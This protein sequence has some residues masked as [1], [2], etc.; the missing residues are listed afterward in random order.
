MTLQIRTCW[1][2]TANWTANGLCYSLSSLR[3]CEP[4]TTDSLLFFFPLLPRRRRHRCR[5]WLS[6]SCS[7]FPRRWRCCHCRRFRSTTNS[8]RW[9]DRQVMWLLVGK[10]TWFLWYRWSW[11]CTVHVAVLWIK[12]D[13]YRIGEFRVY[14]PLCPHPPRERGHN[15]RS[16]CPLTFD[17]RLTNK[18][19]PTIHFVFLSAS[20]LSELAFFYSPSLFETFWLRGSAAT[21]DKLLFQTLPLVPPFPRSYPLLASSISRN[22]NV[23]LQCALPL[24]NLS[25]SLSLFYSNSMMDEWNTK[26]LRRE[27]ETISAVNEQHLGMRRWKWNI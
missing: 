25:F 12:G 13:V 24:S 5:R 21:F 17:V 27:D 26:K 15:L 22:S 14:R 6:S 8:G 1:P 7:S 3:T 4:M 18:N 2:S 10:S 19:K 20:R 11:R 23:G 9:G 16:M